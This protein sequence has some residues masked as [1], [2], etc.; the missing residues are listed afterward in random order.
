MVP[1]CHNSYK[2]GTRARRKKRSQVQAKLYSNAPVLLSVCPNAIDVGEVPR[3]GALGGRGRHQAHRG[4]DEAASAGH[5]APS[6]P[7]RARH[8]PASPLEPARLPGA[9]TRSGGRL[10]LAQ[11]LSEEDLEPQAAVSQSSASET[12]VP[13]NTR[14]TPTGSKSTVRTRNRKV[15]V[16]NRSLLFFFF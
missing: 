9:R 13:G 2:L 7:A 1:L 15:A 3:R 8:G 11:L 12:A 6:P 10:G 16:S 4:R 5:S 14:V